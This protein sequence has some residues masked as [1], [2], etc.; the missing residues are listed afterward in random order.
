MNPYDVIITILFLGMCYL[1]YLQRKDWVATIAAQISSKVAE[2][3]AKGRADIAEFKLA[4]HIGQP[5]P[6]PAPS[7]V[8]TAAPPTPPAPVTP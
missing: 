2:V 3:E 8:V 6:A 1:Y 5:A 4:F 7:P